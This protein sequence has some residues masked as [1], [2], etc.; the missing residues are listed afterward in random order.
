V[1]LLGDAAHVIS[2]FAGDGANLAMSD[3]ADLAEALLQPDWRTA[4]A[5]F[6]ESMSA[7]AE[8]PA[9]TASEIMQEVF[10][11]RGLEQARQH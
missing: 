10:S 9:R 2:P 8:G 6:E 1:T 3:G 5:M 7:R 11:P 4:V